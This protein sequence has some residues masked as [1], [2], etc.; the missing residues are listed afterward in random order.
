MARN[1]IWWL[2][3]A[4]VVILIPGRMIQASA[5]SQLDHEWQ[6]LLIVLLTLAAA[7]LFLLCR[8][9]RRP[10]EPYRAHPA[11]GAGILAL[12][13]GCSILVESLLLLVQVALGDLGWN[14]GLIPVG[15]QVLFATLSG[16]SGIFGGITMMTWGGSLLRTGQ[17]FLEHPIAALFPT[18]WGVLNLLCL[19]MSYTLRPG[20]SRNFLV[21]VP[22][23]L[24][25]LFLYAQA[26]YFSGVHGALGRRK[27]FQ[28]GMPFMLFGF[29][30]SVPDL[31]LLATGGE[32]QTGLPV[33]TLLVLLFLSL[34][35]LSMLLSMRRE[36]SFL[37]RGRNGITLLYGVDFPPDL[38]REDEE[39]SGEE[40]EENSESADETEDTDSDTADRDEEDPLPPENDGT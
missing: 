3:A 1:G 6:L 20:F 13:S 37:L 29:V 40:E 2:L 7:V 35:A 18:V 26:G 32:P 5:S 21:L 10:N 23:S 17:L 22:F 9:K 8:L 33:S 16:L 14:G 15:N 38:P 39:N 4:A 12:L 30:S 36:A 25:V 28:Y 31:L 34:Y 19:F 11:P 27:I 24:A